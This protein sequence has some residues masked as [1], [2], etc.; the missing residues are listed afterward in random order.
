MVRGQMAG[1]ILTTGTIITL[2][3]KPI[4]EV[5]QPIYDR[6]EDEQSLMRRSGDPSMLTEAILDT[7][8][9]HPSSLAANGKPST[10]P[11][12]CLRRSRRIS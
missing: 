5:L 7:G 11:L 10:L 6:L 8:E 4:D 3:R 12:R 9:F 1:R 2:A